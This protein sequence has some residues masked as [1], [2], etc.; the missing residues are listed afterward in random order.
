VPAFD[1]VGFVELAR[2]THC[3]I[4]FVP[5]V[6]DFMIRGEPLF[7]LHSGDAL[8]MTPPRHRMIDDMQ[9]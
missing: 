8:T 6:G 3:V 4:V 7:R 2:R 9:I 1:V 5:Q